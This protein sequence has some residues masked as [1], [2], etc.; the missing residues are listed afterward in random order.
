MEKDIWICDY[1]NC[2]YFGFMAY[3]GEGT[4]GAGGRVQ[5]AVK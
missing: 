1:E 2:E 5:G 3:I 4:S